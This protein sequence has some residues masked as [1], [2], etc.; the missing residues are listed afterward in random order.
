MFTYEDIGKQCKWDVDEVVD[1]L[2]NLKG[3][4]DQCRFHTASVEKRLTRESESISESREEVEVM[5]RDG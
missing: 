4:L 3:M 2:K 5:R 1:I